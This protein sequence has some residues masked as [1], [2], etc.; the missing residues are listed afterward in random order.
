[1]SRSP[2]KR[3]RHD[4]IS[5][6]DWQRPEQDRRPSSS[7][8]R[9]HVPDRRS[10][11]KATSVEGLSVRVRERGG[12]HEAD[13]ARWMAERDRLLPSYEEEEMHRRCVLS[14]WSMV[15]LCPHQ[16]S[17]CISQALD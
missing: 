10:E 1:M 5:W 12:R 11:R 3:G 8:S 2:A 7:R 13:R 4:P 14:V 15:G 17:L 6:R 9:S 16:L